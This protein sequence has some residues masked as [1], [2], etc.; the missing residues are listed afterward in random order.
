MQNEREWARLCADVIGRPELAL[1]PR[2]DSNSKRVANRSELHGIIERGLTAYG[3]DEVGARLEIAQ[4]AWASLNSMDGLLEHP[5]LEARGR[6]RAVQSPVGPLTALLPAVTMEGV[7]PVMGAIPALG[8][9]TNEI[10][11]ELGFE[12]DAIDRW[13][14]EG[15]V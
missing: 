5:Q 10:L 1:D 2:F 4:I 3:A 13:R 11:E 6:W 12:M 14:K 7:E 15:A 9:H 8:E